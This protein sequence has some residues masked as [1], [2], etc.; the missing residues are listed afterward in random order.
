MLKTFQAE[1]FRLNSCLDL[2]SVLHYRK[3]QIAF[4]F[5]FIRNLIFH[6]WFRF[7]PEPDKGINRKS[8]RN[9]KVTSWVT[10]ILLTWFWQ[11]YYIILDHNK[12][13]HKCHSDILK[14][15][16]ACFLDPTLFG[17]SNF[18][19]KHFCWPN[20]FKTDLFFTKKFYERVF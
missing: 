14:T 13:D 5:L 12:S 15:K 3:F 20:F 18:F 16:F 11:K 4:R 7:L 8:G 1:R 17:N 19:L 2:N 9:L 6:T 10:M